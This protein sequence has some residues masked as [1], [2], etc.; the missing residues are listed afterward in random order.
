MCTFGGGH[1]LYISDQSNTNNSS[2]SGLG[3]TYELPTGKNNT[4]LAGTNSFKVLEIEVF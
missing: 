2:Y 3:S 1:D 4:W